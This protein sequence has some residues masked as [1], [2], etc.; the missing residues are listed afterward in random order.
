MYNIFYMTLELKIV[1][2]II[3]KCERL[4]CTYNVFDTLNYSSKLFVNYK[5]LYTFFKIMMF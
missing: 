2:N 5:L 3:Y 1:F 4:L